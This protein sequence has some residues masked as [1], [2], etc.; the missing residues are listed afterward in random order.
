MTKTTNKNITK[1][2][3]RK[4]A[5]LK[6]EEEDEQLIQVVE[7]KIYKPK[8][9][10]KFA[11]TEAPSFEIEFLKTYR[12]FEQAWDAGVKKLIKL[13]ENHMKTKPN[14]RL[15]VGFNYQVV[16]IV[17][18]A[19]YPNPDTVEEEEVKSGV[20]STTIIEIYNIESVKPTLLNLKAN[21]E[22]AF[23]KSPEQ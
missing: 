3:K 16:K 20:C 12:M 4:A 5:A 9:S 15:V 22:F 23:N 13:T 1:Q 6:E 8:V 2:I 14:I 7:H 10:I 18:N 19:D 21:L 17:T 11:D